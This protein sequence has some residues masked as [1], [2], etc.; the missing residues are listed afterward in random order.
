MQHAGV[1]RSTVYPSLRKSAFTS[2]ARSSCLS[3][4][5]SKPTHAHLII[6]RWAYILIVN[7][8]TTTSQVRV[9]RSYLKWNGRYEL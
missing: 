4:G 7:C 2:S 9:A 1:C 6:H 3:L 8:I 5:R